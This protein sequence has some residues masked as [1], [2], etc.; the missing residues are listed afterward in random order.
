MKRLH[1]IICLLALTLG[2]S[3]CDYAQSNV[4]TLVT[5]NCGVTWE[6]IA[7]GQNVPKNPSPCHYKITLPDYPMQGDMVFK[8]TFDD[9]VKARIEVS[10]DYNIID[11]SLFIEEAKYLG[12]KNTDSD[13]AAN[14]GAFEG[15]ENSVIN[16][17]IKEV[18]G[19]LLLKED[20]VEFDQNEFEEKLL[21]EVNNMLERR[22]VRLNFITF[23]PDPDVQTKQA[24]DVATAMRIYESKGLEVVGKQIITAKAG[25]ASIMLRTTIPS[26]DGNEE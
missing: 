24:I 9:R 13:D 20:I 19:N 4:Q 15:A 17:R 7:P 16:K 10:Y 26:Q 1:T 11:G 18:A 5:D 2:L 3:S 12:R 22:G 21:V 23:V 8:G 25:A 14:D 6:V